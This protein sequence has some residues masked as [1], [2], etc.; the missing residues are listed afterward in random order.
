MAA[1]SVF[2]WNQLE[3]TSL[4][5]TY[6]KGCDTFSVVTTKLMVP[7]FSLLKPSKYFLPL[8]WL[9]WPH[10]KTSAFMTIRHTCGR[11]FIIQSEKTPQT[12]TWWKKCV[13]WFDLTANRRF[14]IFK[15]YTEPNLPSST[16]L[17]TAVRGREV[18]R[19]RRLGEES[20]WKISLWSPLSIWIADHFVIA[21]K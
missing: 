6:T 8:S 3:C 16:G 4:L 17:N 13:G 1:T 7:R 18:L 11:P 10:L 14:S 9:R 21:W 15:S 2:V 19:W 12:K 5:F 20:A